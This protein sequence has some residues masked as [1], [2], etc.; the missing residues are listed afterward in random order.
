MTPTLVK[1]VKGFATNSS[2]CHSIVKKSDELAKLIVNDNLTKDHE[3]EWSPFKIK[4]LEAK[5]RYLLITAHENAYGMSYNLNLDNDD[6]FID[7]MM[8]DLGKSLKKNCD[9]FC[10]IWKEFNEADYGWSIDHASLLTI[11]F[12]IWE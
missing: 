12:N 10:N 5:I 4:S 11:P 7:A 6:E 9:T 1:Y 8:Y 3:Y 2:S